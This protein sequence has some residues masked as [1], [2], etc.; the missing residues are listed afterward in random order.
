M[1]DEDA[2]IHHLLRVFRE[3]RA[4]TH[5]IR[6]PRSV[7]KAAAMSNYI[8]RLMDQDGTVRSVIP[9]IGSTEAD[10]ILIARHHLKSS[11]SPGTFELWKGNVRVLAQ[12]NTEGDAPKPQIDGISAPSY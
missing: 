3:D 5:R 8:C 12:G 9:I 2:D 6:M 10:A 11:G 7:P 4:C 1:G